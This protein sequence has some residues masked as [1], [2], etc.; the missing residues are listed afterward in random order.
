MKQLLLM[1]VLLVSSIT[2]A[3]TP[4]DNDYVFD[5]ACAPTAEEIA[6][7]ELKILTDERAQLLENESS[8]TASVTSEWISEDGHVITVGTPPKKIL[9]SEYGHR[10]F[11]KSETFGLLIDA[12]GKAVS[13]L[14]YIKTLATGDVKITHVITPGGFDEFFMSAG[15]NNTG[16]AVGYTQDGSRNQFS[17]NEYIVEEL[18]DADLTDLYTKISNVVSQVQ[19]EYD[20]IN[21]PPLTPRE[22]RI[23][24][25]LG[26]ATGNVKVFHSLGYNDGDRF[27]I[28]Y[29]DAIQDENGN[30]QDQDRWTL[31]VGRDGFINIELL[32]PTPLQD[33]YNLISGSVISVQAIYDARII[34]RAGFVDDL[35]DESTT[36]V[37]VTVDVLDGNDIVRYTDGTTDSYAPLS[38][39]LVDSDQ[40]DINDFI[41]YTLIPAI[42]NLSILS[43]NALS[44]QTQ[45]TY[46]LT[47][48]T[49][50]YTSRLVELNGILNDHGLPSNFNF[51]FSYDQ[52]TDYVYYGSANPHNPNA[53]FKVSDYDDNGSGNLE[54]M[55][56][57]QF[58]IMFAAAWNYVNDNY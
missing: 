51:M 34:K 7:M 43:D 46:D 41:T 40:S 22:I 30:F 55:T 33:F 8:S 52:G 53:L 39:L 19:S 36:S 6:A 27:T 32:E 42:N 48:A 13:R 11:G 24:H 10:N 18:E 17:D 3:Q 58:N 37:I 35:E 57:V 14:D 31:Y 45:S 12:V 56:V 29:E 25:I 20:A 23:N 5:F 49:D 16:N 9:A 50:G 26:L 47:K 2:Y 38:K 15:S 44:G 1:F 21:N 4:T 28:H 54:D